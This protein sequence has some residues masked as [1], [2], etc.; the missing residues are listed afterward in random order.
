MQEMITV[1]RPGPHGV[2]F[3]G[4]WYWDEALYGYRL[5]VSVMQT[6]EDTVDIYSIHDDRFICTARRM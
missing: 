1:N 2:F 6:G 4:G 5:K 3:N